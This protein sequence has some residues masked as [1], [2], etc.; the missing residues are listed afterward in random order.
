MGN[1]HN[2]FALFDGRH[3][4]IVPIRQ[5]SVN[6]GFETLNKSK[7]LLKFEEEEPGQHCDTFYQ[8]WGVSHH[9][10]IVMVGGCRSFFSRFELALSHASLRFL[11]C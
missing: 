11:A 1:D 10:Q 2:S 3:D 9:P 4:S 7:Y 8:V 6:C 5:N